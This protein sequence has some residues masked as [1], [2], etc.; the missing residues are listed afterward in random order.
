MTHDTD[1]HM[2]SSSH[3]DFTENFDSPVHSAKR[4]INLD[5]KRMPNLL[6]VE[7]QYEIYFSSRLFWKPGDMNREAI[8]CWKPIRFDKHQWC[9]SDKYATAYI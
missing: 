5:G 7:V 4:I 6:I 8:I 1:M 9:R 2:E 3:N